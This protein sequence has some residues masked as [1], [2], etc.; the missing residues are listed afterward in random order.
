MHI[1]LCG[2]GGIGSIV[3]EALPVGEE[4][5]RGW[6]SGQN[7]SALQAEKEF[8]EPQAVTRS[9]A[10]MDIIKYAGMVELADTQDLG[11][12]ASQRAGSTPVTRTI[13]KSLL[14]GSKGGFFYDIRLCRN[15]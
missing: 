8:W 6:R 14:S 5:R 15:G 9:V 11:S 4:A 1:V 3:V 13:K 2:Y 7:S 10:A 12:C